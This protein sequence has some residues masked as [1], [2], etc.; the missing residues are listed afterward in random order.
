MLWKRIGN[1]EPAGF[2]PDEDMRVRGVAW[3]VIETSHRDHGKPSSLVQKRET[4]TAHTTEYVGE[5]FGFRELVGLEKILAL[6]KAN[7]IEWNEEIGCEGA[8]AVDSSRY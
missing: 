3:I 5:S 8:S 1:L 6:G 2:G 4:R 7:R